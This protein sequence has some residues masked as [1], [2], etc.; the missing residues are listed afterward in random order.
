MDFLTSILLQ[1]I[2]KNEG[3]PF[4][5][6][7]GRKSHNAEKFESSKTARSNTLKNIFSENAR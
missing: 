6:I 4:E 3:G 2:K 1:N 5:E 7:F